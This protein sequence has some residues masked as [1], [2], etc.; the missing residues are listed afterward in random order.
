MAT[1]ANEMPEVSDEVFALI[2]RELAGG[3]PDEALWTKAFALQNGDESATKAHYIRLRV[4]Q[5]TRNA[6]EEI[7]SDSNQS[8][9]DTRL[10]AGPWPRYFAR[11]L[12][13]TLGV[14]LA[15][16]LLFLLLTMA[17]SSGFKMAGPTWVIFIFKCYRSFRLNKLNNYPTDE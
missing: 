5:I 4:E 12:D 9:K 3:K 16:W 6:S 7:K 13:L 8:T 10:A 11:Y 1:K 15:L 17:T 14:S 2:A